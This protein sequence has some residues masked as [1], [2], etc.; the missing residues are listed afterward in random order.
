MIIRGKFK[1]SN[2]FNKT[3]LFLQK[4]Q[5][6]II[7]AGQIFKQ[8]YKNGLIFVNSSPRNK[9]S[10]LN[11]QVTSSKL[12]DLLQKIQ[13]VITVYIFC[14]MI[15]TA[16]F[17]RKF[18]LWKFSFWNHFEKTASKISARDNWRRSANQFNKTGS[19]KFS[20][21]FIKSRVFLRK[22]QLMIT[23]QLK[24]SRE[25]MKNVFYTWTLLIVDNRTSLHFKVISSKNAFH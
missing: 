7:G 20:N 12:P 16:I 25:F 5:L 21:C 14:G 3:V 13:L 2:H 23:R 10:S 6:M 18:K 1:F 8:I 15:K 9:R 17:L 22:V 19:F 11:F 4:F 24:F